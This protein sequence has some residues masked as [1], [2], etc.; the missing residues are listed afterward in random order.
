MLVKSSTLRKKHHFSFIISIV[1]SYKNRRR[2]EIRGKKVRRGR[3]REKE[4]RNRK[5]ERVRRKRKREEEEEANR[6]L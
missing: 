3:K 2:V 5:E 6:R 1:F 4:G